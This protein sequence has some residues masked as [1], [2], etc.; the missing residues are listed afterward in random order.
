MNSLETKGSKLNSNSNSI[1]PTTAEKVKNNS[2]QYSIDLY[3]EYL[4][5]AKNPENSIK[6]KK[7][8]LSQVNPQLHKSLAIINDMSSTDI[9]PTTAKMSR[10][11]PSSILWIL[12]RKKPS[13]IK[14]S[15]S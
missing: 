3:N 8:D 10:I 13:R 6:Y 14:K 1:I 11:I 12:T 2:E 7:E 4:G 9:I 5:L 15:K